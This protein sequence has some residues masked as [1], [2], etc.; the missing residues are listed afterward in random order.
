MARTGLPKVGQPDTP[1][2]VADRK[3]F[4]FTESAL[5]EICKGA[6]DWQETFEDLLGAG[7]CANSFRHVF[8]Q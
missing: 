7:V 6:Y 1:T 2:L 5:N 3:H 8:H 4:H